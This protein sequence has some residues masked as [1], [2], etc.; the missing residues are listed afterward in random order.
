MAILRLWSGLRYSNHGVLMYDY[1]YWFP[2]VMLF[3]CLEVDFA[4]MCASIPIFW[5]TVKAVWNQIT[6]TKEV[7]VT[8]ESRYQNTQA[9]YLEMH[10]DDTASLDSQGS[11]SGLIAEESM[12][13]KSFYIHSRSDTRTLPYPESPRMVSAA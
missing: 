7:I 9:E 13:G 3:S 4:I 12:E 11:K 1:T 6:V 2:C 10:T 8:S 5:P